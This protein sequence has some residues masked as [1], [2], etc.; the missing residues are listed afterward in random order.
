MRNKNMG[1]INAV[2]VLGGGISAN[3]LLSPATLARLDRLL[4]DR[5]ILQSIPVILSGRWS[6]FMEVEPNTTEAEEMKKYL[7]ER[8]VDAQQIILETESLDTISNAVFVRMIIERHRDWKKI[9]LITSDWHMKRALW[10][11]QQVLGGNYQVV[12]LSVISSKVKKGPRE[13]Y[14]KYLLNVAKKFLK[15]I[16]GNSKE[17]IQLLRTEHPFYSKSERAQKLLKEIAAEKEKL[18]P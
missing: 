4:K 13:N 8:G 3:G 5:T 16:R 12:P 2:V 1:E 9:L 6:G 11:F 17:L 18:S 7:V 14:E 10:I 15:D